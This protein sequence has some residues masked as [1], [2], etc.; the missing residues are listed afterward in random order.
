[1]A[2]YRNQD[3]TAEPVRTNDNSEFGRATGNRSVF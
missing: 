1:V 3:S 2:A